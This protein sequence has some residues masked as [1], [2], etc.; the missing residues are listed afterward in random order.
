MRTVNPTVHHRQTERILRTA[1]R[2]FA[3]HG[4]E[5]TSMEKI[6]SACGVRKASLYHYYRS[7]EALLH[8][9]ISTR[10]RKAH[11][12]AGFPQS[13]GMEAKLRFVGT[14][15]LRDFDNPESRQFFQ[16][17]LQDSGSNSYVRKAFFSV[18]QASMRETRESMKKFHP[19]HGLTPSARREHMR[20][21][22]QFLGS[23]FSYT[24]ESKMWK[25]GPS[26]MF[27]DREYV[28]SLA[29]IFARGLRAASAFLIS[30]TLLV[31]ALA[32][33]AT[34]ESLSLDQYMAQVWEKSPALESARQ[35]REGLELKPLEIGMA[36]SPIF[37]ASYAFVDNKS[38]PTSLLSPDRAKI[39][40]WNLGLSKKWFTGTSLSLS[41]GMTGNELFYPPVP[42]MYASMVGSFLPPS[43]TFTAKPVVSVSQSLLRDFMGGITDWGIEK[44]KRAAKAGERMQ[45]YGQQASLMQAEMAY[46]SLALARETVG[47]K[48]QA[49]ERTQRLN[50]WTARRAKLNLTDPADLLQTES[51]LR[52][53]T[54]DL[55]MAEEDA[56]TAARKFNAA[57]GI[58]GAE[59]PAT[60]DSL[61]EQIGKVTEQPVKTSE[62]LDIQAA[63]ESLESA[64]A[65]SKETFYRSLPDLSV[66]GSVGWN[67]YDITAEQANQ[68]A[69]DQKWPVWTVGAAFIA[70]LDLITLAKVRK[71]YD[72]D[73]TGARAATAKSE[74]DASQDWA[75]LSKKWNDVKARLELA[76]EIVKLQEQRLAA[77]QKRLENGRI[78]TYQ[79]ITTQGD[80]ASAQLT[81]LRL[82]MEKISVE[83]QARMYNSAYGTR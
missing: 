56:E 59:A 41:Y 7:K 58:D 9:L 20:S 38:E 27:S 26:R 69:M 79:F 12:P 73:F 33:A 30:L 21:M 81:Y 70:P 46:W 67:G 47:F 24:I 51:A 75:S 13:G 48:K 55:R 11:P 28:N 17:L 14:K 15:M 61:G 60:L 19:F 2:F 18:A 53:V 78:L 40:Q 64:R 37:N 4:Y 23:L 39:T 65:A 3:A 71:G 34:E 80:L 83:A 10:L 32:R 77:D 63:R 72:S 44:T 35:S 36:Y 25:A 62:R 50:E 57:R 43:E 82:G 76:Q 5:N 45:A 54:L 68:K 22:H 31:P 8:D 49:L 29:H 16:L 52:L 1:L 66:F 74:L 6:A 42:P